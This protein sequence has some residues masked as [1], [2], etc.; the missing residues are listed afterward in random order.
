MCWS[1]LADFFYFKM[2]RQ[3]KITYFHNEIY[4][5]TMYTTRENLHM[6]EKGRT[7]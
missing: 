2:H 1:E 3:E 6:I 5:C 4:K 7:V